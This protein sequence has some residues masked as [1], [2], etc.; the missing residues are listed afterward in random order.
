M[1]I[2]VKKRGEIMWIYKFVHFFIKIFFF[3]I[4]DNKRKKSLFWIYLNLIKKKS[5]LSLQGSLFLTF[6]VVH[7]WKKTEKCVIWWIYTI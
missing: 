7:P 1:Q 2:D 4:G 5:V 6:C 3:R